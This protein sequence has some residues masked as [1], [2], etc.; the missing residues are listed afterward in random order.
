MQLYCTRLAV[1]LLANINIQYFTKV[2][3][4]PAPLISGFSQLFRDLLILEIFYPNSLD[5]FRCFVIQCIALQA[6]PT[7]A[8][9]AVIPPLGLDA[10]WIGA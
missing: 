1:Q 3:R 5:R 8:T 4:M 9:H 2:K 7:L 6:E 10:R